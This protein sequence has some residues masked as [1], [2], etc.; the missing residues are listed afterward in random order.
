MGGLTK[1]EG[2]NFRRCVVNECYQMEERTQRIFDNLKTY[3][4]MNRTES[5]GYVEVQTFTWITKNNHI[6]SANQDGYDLLDMI[7]S[8]LT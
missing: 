7:L 8:P 1:Y 6:N 4:R 2:L 3:P 5:E